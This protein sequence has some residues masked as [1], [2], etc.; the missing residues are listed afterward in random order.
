LDIGVWL[1]FHP[2]SSDSSRYV[3]IRCHYRSDT[4]RSVSLPKPLAS[5]E[6]HNI[7]FGPHL[8]GEDDAL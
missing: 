2:P 8:E 7:T 3:D 6:C 1:P 4:T 5:A